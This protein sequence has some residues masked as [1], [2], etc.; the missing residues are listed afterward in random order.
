MPILPR[1]VS[2]HILKQGATAMSKIAFH[3]TLL[4]TALVCLPPAV[5]AQAQSIR[6]FV[7]VAGSDGNPCSITQP[8][9]HFS[10]AVAVTAAG[11]EVDA[12][13][14]GAYGSFAISQAISIEGQGW[15]YVAPPGNGAAI[16]INAG[17]SDKVSIHGVSLN[18]VGAA[19][20]TIGIKFNSG[21]GLSVQDSLIQNF[22]NSGIAFIPSASTPSRIAVSNTRVTNN[23]AVGIAITPS[24]NG[25]V[26][27]VLDRV[28]IINNSSTGLNVI[29][30]TGAINVIVT[31]SVCAGNGDDGI[32]STGSGGATNVFV[33][34]S[35][36][37]GNGFNNNGP[38]AVNGLFATGPGGQIVVTRS[39]I[40]ANAV[41]WATGN[42]AVVVSYDDNNIDGNT[43]GNTAPPNIVYK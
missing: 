37:A 7:S 21:G 16:T 24:G 1:R 4:V 8:C 22:T 33:R 9:R 5:P 15:S 28:E 27:G 20:S 23:A 29:G 35:T 43:G 2:A 39:T 12:L 6:T 34:N 25:P 31:D 3:V 18:G 17:P 36:I 41:G 11:G 13:D 26:A 14:P 19:G 30:N 42:P 38:Q 10:A 40:T 32:A